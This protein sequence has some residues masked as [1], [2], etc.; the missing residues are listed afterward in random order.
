MV[1]LLSVLILFLGAVA[2]LFLN[3]ERRFLRAVSF[4]SPFAALLLLLIPIPLPDSFSIVWH[5]GSLFPQPLMFHASPAAITFTICF[6]ILLILLELARPPQAGFPRVVRLLYFLLTIAG[7]VACTASN[8]LSVALLWSW[9]DF[10]SFLA[11]LLLSRSSEVGPHGI[12]SSASRSI[13]ILSMNFLGTALI[14]F[15]VLSNP[16]AAQT[17]WILAWNAQP[18]NLALALFLC[19][20]ALRLLVLPIQL[21]SSRVFT[22]SAGVDILLRILSPAIV[23]ALLSNAWPGQIFA[24]EG[25][26]LRIWALFFFAALCLWAGLH[27]WTSSPPHGRRVLF[28]LAVPSFAILAAMQT[29]QPGGIFHA[30][31]VTVILG[32]G[33]ILLYRGFLAHRRW[34]SVI[35]IFLAFLQSGF[36]F[37]PMCLVTS[38]LFSGRMVAETPGIFLLAAA[39]QI[40]VLSSLLRVSFDPIEEF[41]TGGSFSLV[42]HTLGMALAAGFM[43][44]PGWGGF[45]SPGLTSLLAPIVFLALAAGI[46]LA[47]RRLQ[48]TGEGVLRLLESAFRLDWLRSLIVFVSGRILV[49]VSR[50][51]DLLSGEGAMLWAFGLALLLFLVLRGG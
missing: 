48:R 26:P 11:I 17:E 46:S 49:F 30:A 40:L 37:L 44:Y 25:N 21:S 14:L 28:L 3:P 24:A 43:F 23:L 27:W 29:A 10:L 31:G 45:I 39:G 18:S 33:M 35:P 13:G 7:I 9:I 42:F 22:S 16:S 20:I 34:M 50:V 5:P 19:G 1:I 12:T 51:E 2:I 36:P 15:P 38:N 4:L 6:C 47:A 8:A 41:Q 32:G